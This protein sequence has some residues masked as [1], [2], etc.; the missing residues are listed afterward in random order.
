MG[1]GVYRTTLR[2]LD[3]HVYLPLITRKSAAR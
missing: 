1:S 2:P 3:Q